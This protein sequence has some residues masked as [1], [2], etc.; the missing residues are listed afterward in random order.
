MRDVR[1]PGEAH[2]VEPDARMLLMPEMTLTSE[3]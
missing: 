3:C 2:Q 1:I